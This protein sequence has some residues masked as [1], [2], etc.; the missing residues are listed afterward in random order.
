[1]DLEESTPQLKIP[2]VKVNSASLY[3]VFFLY[4]HCK[5]LGKVGGGKCYPPL[6]LGLN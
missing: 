4:S 2:L 3:L 5:D 1:M 6:K